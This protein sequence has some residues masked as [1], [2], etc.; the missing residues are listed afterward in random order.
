MKKQQLQKKFDIKNS[1]NQIFEGA[2]DDRK[3]NWNQYFS[4]LAKIYNNELDGDSNLK[5]YVMSLESLSDGEKKTIFALHNMASD[6][7]PYA[8]RLRKYCS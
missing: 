4:N 2:Q 5:T 8:L 3:S 7:K 6:D 1:L